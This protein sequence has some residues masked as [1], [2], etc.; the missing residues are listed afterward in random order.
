MSESLLKQSEG[1]IL[2]EATL[3][4]GPDKLKAGNIR[5]DTPGTPVRSQGLHIDVDLVLVDV[6][7]T[8]HYVWLPIWI[9][10]SSRVFEDNVEQ[11]VLT[12]SSEDVPISIGVIFDF[13]GSMANKI[14]K[15]RQAAVESSKPPIGRTSFSSSA[16]TIERS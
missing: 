3:A 8:D 6:T 13:S 9:L 10:I 11:E 14:G 1:S 4:A 2:S 12:L 7:V 16:S 15:S 5:R